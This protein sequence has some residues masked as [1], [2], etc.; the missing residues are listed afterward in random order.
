[1]YTNI[2]T[3]HTLAKI[4]AFLHISP[5]AAAVNAKPII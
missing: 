3:D 1:M 5:I 4:S 2:D